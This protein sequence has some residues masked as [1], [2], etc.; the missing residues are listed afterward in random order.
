GLD[1]VAIQKK[2]TIG[3]APSCSIQLNLP[4]VTP[5]HAT[6]EYHPLTRSYWLRDHSIMSTTVNGH[7]VVGQ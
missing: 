7:A 1:G 4:G 2:T 3:S 5:L 6:I